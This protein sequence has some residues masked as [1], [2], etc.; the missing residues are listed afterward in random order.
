MKSRYGKAIKLVLLLLMVGC[1]VFKFGLGERTAHANRSGPVPSLTDAPA[2]GT[3]SAET[4]CTSCHFGNS[5]NATGGTLTITAPAS[6]EPNQKYTIKVA[7]S[8]TGLIRF[9]FEI[10]AL[11]ETGKPAGTFTITDSTRT[12]LI[13]GDPFSEFK[14][15]KYVEQT[16]AGSA[17]PAGGSA[18]AT[19]WAFD[20]TAP[21]TRIG[22]ITFYAAGNA[23]NN[24]NSA[25]GDFIYTKTATVRPSVVTV[26]G[27]SF[28]NT[29]SNASNS[30]IVSGFGVDLATATATATGDADPNT[31]GIQLPSTLGGTTVTVRDSLNATH[32][33]TLFYVSPTQVNYLLPSAMANGVATVTFTSGNGTVSTGTLTIANVKPGIFTV[34]QG[35]SGYAAAQIQRVR[36]GVTIGFEDV[37]TGPVANP[38]A[39]PIEWK[40]AGDQLYLVIYGTGFRQRTQLSNVNV[41]VKGAVQQV[42]YAAAHTDF[43]G[44][45]QSNVLLDRSLAGSGDTNV[46]M[47]VDG[48][49]A[50]TVKIN[51]K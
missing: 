44:L 37:A 46:V 23:A 27:A 21:A 5:L 10:T 25:I 41:T 31:P 19:E 17:I 34:N 15:R 14:D 12:Q 16:A 35:G 3:F 13:D 2:L 8:R 11:D 49:T 38:V 9:G 24:S 40:D 39:V 48:V 18:G 45:D 30:S 50:N 6:Y 28:D 33:A 7:L 43:A 36:N 32:N 22:K 51:F 47:T 4:N 42:V 20:W 26:S 1:F 29:T